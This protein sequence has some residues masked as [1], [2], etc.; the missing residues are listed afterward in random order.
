MNRDLALK[1]YEDAARNLHQEV[2]EMELRGLHDEEQ[3]QHSIRALM[4][5][6]VAKSR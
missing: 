1:I 2:E 5:V 4:D 3:A 6:F